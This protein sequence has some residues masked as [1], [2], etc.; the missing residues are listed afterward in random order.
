MPQPEEG[1][2][3]GSNGCKGASTDTASVFRLA[4]EAPW[5]PVRGVY[6]RMAPWLP[7]RGVTRRMTPGCRTAGEGSYSEDGPLVAG[8]PVRGVTRRMAPWVPD[9]R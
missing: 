5:V 1:G 2:C 8:L 3:R 4:R 7:V 9:C 6:Q